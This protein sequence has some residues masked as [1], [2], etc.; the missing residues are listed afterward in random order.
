[1][2]L[3]KDRDRRTIYRKLKK[4]EYD[5]RI[6]LSVSTY[7]MRL[8]DEGMVV[9]GTGNPQFY[10]PKGLLEK[11]L[12]E[13]PEDIVGTINLGHMPFANFPI[14]LGAWEK[15]DLELV[16]LDNGFKAVDVTLHLNTDLHIVQDLL[17]MPYDLGVSAEVFLTWDDELTKFVSE[18]V[19]DYVP[20]AKSVYFDAFAIV[21][22]AGNVNSFGLKGD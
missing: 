2:K 16:D 6:N 20:V 13:F 14:I 8:L 21:G 1:M 10:I 22:D 4:E 15:S 17:A 5:E 12:D 9:T 19:G 11:F 3:I 7:K 18:K